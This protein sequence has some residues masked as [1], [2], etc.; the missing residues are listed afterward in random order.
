[1]RAAMASGHLTEW[2]VSAAASVSR[3]FWA[4]AC[5][6][7]ALQLAAAGDA[8]KAASYYL[9]VHKVEEAIRVLKKAEEFAAAVAV[10]K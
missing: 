9:M 5:E 2:M 3:D 1:M 10:A 8:A 4:E 6:A 7:F